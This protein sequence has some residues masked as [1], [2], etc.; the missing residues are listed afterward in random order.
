[1]S[2]KLFRANGSLWNCGDFWI[3][4]HSPELNLTLRLKSDAYLLMLHSHAQVLISQFQTTN[5]Y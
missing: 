4:H 1:M 3:V 2:V 5:C